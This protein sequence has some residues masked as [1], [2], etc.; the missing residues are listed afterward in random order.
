MTEDVS[1]IAASL[2]KAQ[3]DA[4][5]RGAIGDHTMATVRALMSRGLMHLRIDSPN[6]RAGFVENTT[7]GDK[8]AAHLTQQ[9]PVF[10]YRKV[11]E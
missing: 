2:T 5:M 1:K 11:G 6:G 8:V 7:L 3:R 4:V 9:T 10:G